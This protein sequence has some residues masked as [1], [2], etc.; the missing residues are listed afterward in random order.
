MDSSYLEYLK[1]YHA[2]NKIRLGQN[3]D[4][5]YVIVDL[6]TYDCYISAG[7]GDDESF[8][9]DFIDKY[10]NI[11]SYF[12][13][14]NTIKKLPDN[15][16]EKMV[17]ISK[18]IAP[19]SKDDVNNSSL[20]QEMCSYE[21]IFLKMDIEGGEYSWLLSLHSH[22]LVRFKQMVFEFHGVHNDDWGTELK[23]KI[24]CFKHIS[25]THYLVHVHANN[26]GTSVNVN[27]NIMPTV[28]EV[29]YIRK[30]ILGA[31]VELNK[32]PLPLVDLDYPTQTYLPEMD[33]SFYPFV[34][35]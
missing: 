5:G 13:Y 8:S 27:G 7:I 6:D 20:L 34:N 18:N 3:R 15:F 23:R 24:E 33:L 9:R 4:G 16:P 1:V 26:G 2:D 19:I 28:I 10:P 32:N 11:R 14:D 12:A 35:K 31:T 22:L 17:H 29:T 30:D 21:N 25:N